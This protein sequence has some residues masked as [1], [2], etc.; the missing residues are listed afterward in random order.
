[1]LENIFQTQESI[2]LCEGE[3]I[4]INNEVIFQDTTISQNLTAINGC[5]STHTFFIAFNATNQTSEAITICQGDTIE[6]FGQAVFEANTLSQTFSNSNNCDSTH[7]VEVILQNIF[8]TQETIDLCSGDSIT[9]DNV[10]YFQDAFFIQN[11][12]AVNGCDSLHQITLDFQD[13]IYQMDS[14]LLCENEIFIFFDDTISTTGQYEFTQSP[15]GAGCDTIYQLMVNVE[16]IPLPEFF[17]DPEC[18]N[19]MNGQLEIINVQP[20]WMFSIDGV[21]YQASPIFEMLPSGNYQLWVENEAGCFSTTPFEIASSVLPNISLPNDASLALGDTLTMPISYS[22]TDNLQFNW[23]PAN[24][25]SCTTCPFPVLQGTSSNTY[26]IEIMDQFGCTVNASIDIT[27][28]QEG[29]FIPNAFTPN[30]D[31]NNDRFT[32][33][34]GPSIEKIDLLQ[35]YDS[36]GEMIFERRDFAPND[37]LLGWDGTFKGKYMNNGVFVYKC[38]ITTPQDGEIILAGDVTLIR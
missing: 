36:W 22:S 1:L 12:T 25:L 9:I 35:I 28:F 21:N 13:V 30:G 7:T 10:T 29:I 14:V 20:N 15:L 4:N 24:G 5:D 31:E 27:I 19:Q 11:L 6:V 3:S 32:V 16:A 2:I 37:D 23:S 38:H 18:L 8:Q 33:Y 26:T 17:I 34:T